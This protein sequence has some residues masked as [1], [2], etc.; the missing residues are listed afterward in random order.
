MKFSWIDELRSR[1]PV[2]RLCALLGVSA[3]GYYAWRSR[4]QSDHGRD[5]RRLRVEIRAVF[6]A[7]RETYGTRRIQDELH[8]QGVLCSRHRIARLMRESGLQ[9]KKARQFRVTT[10]LCAARPVAENRL[11]QCFEAAR[12]DEIWAADITYIRTLEGWLYLAVILDL[13]S[14]RIVGWSLR[15]YLDDRLPLEAL[16]RALHE[17]SAPRIH[18]SDRGSQYASDDYRE[19]LQVSGIDQSMSRR[20]NCYDN[21]PVESFF[22]SLKTEEVADRVYRTRQA[23]RYCIVDYIERFYNRT[24][25]HSGVGGLSPAA[26]EQRLSEAPGAPVSVGLQE[27]ESI[28]QTNSLPERLN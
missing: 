10:H 9:A 23:A 16:R 12:P 17:R 26:F 7:S 5:D 6:K 4:P 14:R 24:R 15:P 20:G 18:H 8:D 25:R 2:Q 22:D 1:H 13:C 28:A 3:S 19:L 11:D 21:A 27:L